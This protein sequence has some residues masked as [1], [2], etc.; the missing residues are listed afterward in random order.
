MRSG[1]SERRPHYPSGGGRW[2]EH[3]RRNALTVTSRADRNDPRLSQKSNFFQAVSHVTSFSSNNLPALPICRLNSVHVNSRV[4]A[5]ANA[6]APSANRAFFPS[7]TG[8]PS[9]PMVV[10]TTGNPAAQASRIFKR[11]PLPVSRGT[12]AIRERASSQTASTTGLATS[13]RGSPVVNRRTA[14]AFFPTRRHTR[15]GHCSRRR[16]QISKRKK[17]TAVT[18]G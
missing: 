10:E 6:S 7:W 5:P 15:F 11:V 18:F 12:T 9:A 14:V 8:S 1:G 13:I 16:G 4:I 17:R 2:H 3:Q